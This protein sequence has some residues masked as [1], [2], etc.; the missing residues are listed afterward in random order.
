MKAEARPRNPAPCQ[1][2]R[3]EAII[4]APLRAGAGHLRK[5]RSGQSESGWQR[6]GAAR[7]QQ[8]GPA[9]PNDFA[10]FRIRPRNM[11]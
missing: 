2:W 9:L 3:Q 4:H 11:R 8:P 1:E 5:Q 10:A 7:K 6:S